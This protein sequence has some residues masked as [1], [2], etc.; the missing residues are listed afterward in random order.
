[1]R[2]KK[3]ADYQEYLVDSLKNP[4]EAAAYLDAVLEEGDPKLLL[5]ALKNI[6]EARGGMTEVAKRTKLNRVS[7]YRALSPKGNPTF[8]S[9]TKILDA[10][11]LR[12]AVQS[13]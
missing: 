5:I 7:L 12:L 13:K 3:S 11:D 8:Q 6:A 9:I 4:K 2:K 1:M 10:F